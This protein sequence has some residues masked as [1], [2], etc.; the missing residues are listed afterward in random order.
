MLLWIKLFPGN[1]LCIYC[2][3]LYI[4]CREDHIIFQKRS[5]VTHFKNSENQWKR[6]LCNMPV[7]TVTKTL[8][9]TWSTDLE[10]VN[11]NE[12]RKSREV[13]KETS[14]IFL[15]EQKQIRS[16]MCNL[17]SSYSNNLLFLNYTFYFNSVKRMLLLIKFYCICNLIKHCL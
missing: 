7:V 12:V 6:V 2:E 5:K 3:Y 9:N 10:N 15:T 8:C 11:K 16:H 1:N 13:V 14:D 4:I 17:S